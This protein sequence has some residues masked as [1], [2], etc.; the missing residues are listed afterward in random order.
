MNETKILTN[1]EAVKDAF[2]FAKVKYGDFRGLKNR[3]E[4]AEKFG[5]E[6]LQV[7]FYSNGGHGKERV[8]IE[9][10]IRE[11]ENDTAPDHVWSIRDLVEELK[12]IKKCEIEIVAYKWNKWRTERN[13]IQG[14]EY[15]YDTTLQRN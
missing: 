8:E 10:S 14:E 1:I 7:L 9:V 12:D 13:R 11:N 5:I 15:I 6:P 3:F 2:R 4:L